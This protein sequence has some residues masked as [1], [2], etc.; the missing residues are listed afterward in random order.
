[1]DNC[2]EI[3]YDLAGGGVSSVVNKADADAMNWVEG[4]HTWGT[5]KN[6]ELVSVTPT[7]EGVTA[8]Y[9]T[10]HLTVTVERALTGGRLREKYRFKNRLE[11][12]VF[13]NRGAVGIYA[14]F[15]D[16]YEKA[17]ISM[18]QRCSTHIWCGG[19]S[20]YVNAVKMGPCDFALGLVLLKGSLD[21]YSV[22]RDYA[23]SSDDRGDF[24]LHPSPFDLRPGEEM[25]LE[26]E[27]FWY[28]TGGFP[29][30]L[31]KYDNILTVEAAN[32]T[33]LP[34]EKI[35]FS[36]NRG[37]A[38]V[39]LG[40]L[41]V[42]TGTRGGRTY[43]DFAPERTGEHRFT[44]RYGGLTTKVEFFVHISFEELVRRR[45]EFIVDKQQFS[46]QGSALDGAY[47]IY[48]NQDKC[49][50]FDDLNGDYNASR[51]RL[52]MGILI[53][54]YLQ[55]R[56]DPKISASLFK[57]YEFVRREFFDEESCIVYNTIGKNPQFKRLYNGPWMSMFMME[58]YKL[59][60]DAGYL[61]KLYGIMVNYY[62]AGG[63]RFYP[64][65]LS[66]YETVEVMRQ[67][68][69]TEMAEKLTAMYR[70]H[71]D[72]IVSIGLKYPT[73]EVR[74]EQTIVTPAV[75]LIAQMYMLTGDESLLEACRLHMN[76][77]DRFNGRQ[78]SHYLNDVSLR[79]WD[80]YWFGK[81]R[82][83]GDTLPH[84]A[85]IHTS[86]AFWHYAKISG[87][88]E[89]RKRAYSGARNVLSLF[90][91]DGSASCTYLYPF[92]VNGVRCEYYDEF[93]NEQDGALYYLIKYFD[94]LER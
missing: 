17:P 74:Y 21:S 71:V 27:L 31:E 9:K 8:V 57:Y 52:V 39:F 41:P 32:Y 16:S 19:S 4:D 30:E 15:N 63:G 93:A 87:D 70:G 68:G 81:R 44:V 90:N 54:K 7:D 40:D 10:R 64:N 66:M 51:E 86:V 94:M 42:E 84:S 53:A 12:D 76:V 58:L 92:S 82:I 56:S 23:H 62:D 83:F 20:S 47:L 72:N 36:V 77:L 35:S 88:E 24:I 79:F 60:G 61:D 46:C 67:A 65:G 75:N 91:E 80:G 38:E 5:V 18:T 48:D 28:K 50:I 2:F 85:S 49:L 25:T 69:K 13:F 11:S 55:Y 45:I 3:K 73:H 29:A 78:P 6:S 34:G 43:V 26:W 1:M 89:Y 14:T 37:D 59:T 33:L 22:E